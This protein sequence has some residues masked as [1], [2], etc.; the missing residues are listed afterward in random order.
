MNPALGRR[1]RAGVVRIRRK[2]KTYRYLNGKGVYKR[3]RME[4][5]IP[6]KFQ[7]VVAPFLHTDLRIEARRE[8]EN[9]IIKATPTEKTGENG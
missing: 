2:I 7:D 5:T 4:L 3:K 1:E 9:L 6:A 8:G